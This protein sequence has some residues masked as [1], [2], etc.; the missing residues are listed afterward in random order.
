MIWGLLNDLSVIMTLAMITVP[1]PGV[2]SMIQSIILNIIYLD[3]L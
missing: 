2:A 1:V 3:I